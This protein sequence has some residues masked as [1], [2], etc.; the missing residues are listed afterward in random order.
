MWRAWCWPLAL[1]SLQA[2]AAPEPVRI[3]VD[4]ANSTLSVK[5]GTST[6]LTVPDVAIGRYG[7]TAQKRRG[8]GMTPLGRYRVA[9]LKPNHGHHYF[10]GIDYPAVDDARRGHAAGLINEAQLRAIERAH[11]DGRVPPQDTPLGGQIGIHGIGQGD[12]EVHANYNWTRGC[13]AVTDVQLDQLL[14]WI[15]LGTPVEIR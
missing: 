4:T 7:A 5:R 2:V 1:L 14:P 8:D 10:I 9:W 15:R 11:R 3:L 6:L 13:V 12:P